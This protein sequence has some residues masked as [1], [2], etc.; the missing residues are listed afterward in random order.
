MRFTLTLLSSG[1]LTRLLTFTY[2]PNTTLTVGLLTNLYHMP[3]FWSLFLPVL[4]SPLFAAVKPVAL[5]AE[6]YVCLRS[7]TF[8]GQDWISA[9]YTYYSENFPSVW[10]A[11]SIAEIMMAR[12]NGNLSVSVGSLCGSACASF[13]S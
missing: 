6:D 12:R 3:H 7:F 13:T 1:L 11:T 8:S 10:N 2:P 4:Q 9:M 5:Y